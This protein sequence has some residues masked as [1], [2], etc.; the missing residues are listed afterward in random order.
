[1]ATLFNTRISDT[2][3]GLIKTIDNAA[4]SA[5]LKQL[6][7]GS[8]NLTGLFLNSAGDFKVT[9]ILEFGT[10][11]DSNNVGILTF[12]TAADG[13]ENFDNDTSVP[14][15]AAVKNYVDSEVTSQDLDFTANSGSGDVDLDSEVFDIRGANGI[16]TSADVNTLT[17]DGTELQNGIATNVTN[18]ATN[19]TNIAAN[20][21]NITTNTADIAT[22]VTGIATNATNIASN[23]TDIA[24]NT[25]NIN[26][27]AD[28]ITNN[29]SSISSNATN[30]ATNLG[31]INTNASNI[32]NNATNIV[33]NVTNIATNAT[34]IDSNELSIQNNVDNIAINN[35]LINDN[36]TDITAN[37]TNI[38]TNVTNIATNVADINTINTT[39]EFLVNKGQPSGYVP[40]DSNSKILETYLPASV[41]GALKYIG[42]WDALNDTPTLP[43]ATTNNG[44]YYIV[45]V[46][47]TYLSVSYG[48]GDWIVSNGV[49]YQKIDNTDSVSTVFGRLGNVLANS[50]DYDAFYPTLTNLP[51]LI[52]NNTSVAANTLKVGIT[53]AQADE[54]VVNSAKVGI[55]TAQADEIAVNTLK[56]GI[57]TAQANE[58]TANTLKVGITTAQSNEITANTLKVGITTAQADEITANTAKTGITTAQANEITANTA[59]VGITTAQASEIAVNTL[60]VGYTEAAVSANA[61]VVANTAKVGITTQQAADIVTNNGK[62]GIT[63][64]QTNAIIGNTN[65]I[66]TNAVAITG[67]VA[68]TGDIM[69]G[70]LKITSNST[71]ALILSSTQARLGIRRNTPEAAL[72][73]GANAR[74]RGS[75]NVG[76]T[77]EQYLFVST[78][79]DTPVGYVKM[80]RYGTGLDYD[81]TNTPTA[82]PQYT[83]AFGS[84]GRVVEDIRYYTFKLTRAQMAA[85]SST[86]KTLIPAASGYNYFIEDAYF[87]QNNNNGFAPVYNSGNITLD[88]VYSNGNTV[89]A[90]SVNATIAN[91]NRNYRKIIG[92]QRQPYVYGDS[93]ALDTMGVQLNAPSASNNGSGNVTY[94]LR[95]KVKKVNILNDI[96]SN[97]QII[98]VS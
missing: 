91:N 73:V 94:F 37:A 84:G 12:I 20:T 16:N 50:T 53:T 29:S 5:S 27:N 18:I 82:T 13:I 88:Y 67:K 71:T 41:I 46:A 35:D 74:V 85:L 24:A 23:D 56:D 81:T 28:N 64:D 45:S 62:V 14:T 66:A 31:L 90:A 75:L 11:K 65:N 54:I 78:T 32:A 34:D 92:L 49:D 22:N 89:T 2:Y 9:N 44:N 36:I 8:G 68:K 95:L 87:L 15:T 47:G 33:T 43:S 7:D 80:G 61:S 96:S 26:T 59:K 57:T 21:T 25:T 30:I 70:D 39:A 60:K 51:S 83:A 42:T 72:D 52:T 93:N 3:E 10:L 38:A 77:N 76:L 58:I 63:T 6:S 1:M 48:I 4:I 40:L 69:T 55:T 86:P 98:V 19:A 97:S 17:I 79:G